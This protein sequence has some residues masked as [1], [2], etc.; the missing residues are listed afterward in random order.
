MFSKPQSPAVTATTIQNVIE[1][2][3]NTNDWPMDTMVEIGDLF[4]GPSRNNESEIAHFT[5]QDLSNS[6]KNA[7]S[8]IRELCKKT[9]DK[10]VWKFEK[11][12]VRLIFVFGLKSKPEILTGSMV[13]VIF[14]KTHARNS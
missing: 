3:K 6:D 8:K 2:M 1:K 7:E 14:S 12:G 10:Y 11:D 5:Y 13:S 9:F 4:N